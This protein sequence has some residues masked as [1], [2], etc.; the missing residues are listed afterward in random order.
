MR[1]LVFEAFIIDLETNLKEAVW[2][3]DLVYYLWEF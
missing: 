3:V 2:F 1:V